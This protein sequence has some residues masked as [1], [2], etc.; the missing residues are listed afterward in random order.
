MDD[1]NED[2]FDFNEYEPEPGEFCKIKIE[3]TF[4]ATYFPDCPMWPWIL[5]LEKPYASRVSSWKSEEY[6]LSEDYNE[7]AYKKLL[8]IF[9]Q[10]KQENANFRIDPFK[11]KNKPDETTKRFFI[12]IPREDQK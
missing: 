10:S 4:Y 2:Y 6:N 7:T 12:Y 5:D 1:E 8:E 11:E 9:H 3:T